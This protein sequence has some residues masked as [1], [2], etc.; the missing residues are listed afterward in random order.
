VASHIFSNVTAT[1]T[2][3]ASFS[4]SSPNTYTLTVYRGGT[5]TGT[6]TSSPSGINCGTD[7]NEAYNSGTSV[8]LTPSPNTGSIFTGW[9]G[10]PDCSDGSVT[11]DASKSCTAT[12]AE[13]SEQFN[14]ISPQNRSYDYVYSV[15]NAGITTGCTQDPLNY[16]PSDKVTRAAMAAFIIRAK[17]GE[18]FTY[19]TTPYFTDVPPSHQFFKY[20]QKMRQ[21]GIYT[22][23]TSTRYCPKNTVNR[24][25]MAAFLA[26]AFLGMQ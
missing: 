20:I 5:G 6:V 25:W 23:C 21:E 1:H 19:P 12:F 15:Y 14:D 7:C 4:A 13:S 26:R 2:I 17:Y 10:N 18:Q 11:I 9:S 24:L 16:C 3:S 8:T 22:G